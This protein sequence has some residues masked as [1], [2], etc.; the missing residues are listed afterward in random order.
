MRQSGFLGSVLPIAAIVV[1]YSR[2]TECTQ[3]SG[4]MKGEDARFQWPQEEA[5]PRDYVDVETNCSA[6]DG[7][8]HRIPKK[9]LEELLAEAPRATVK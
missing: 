2:P 9:L 3:E 5:R 7:K 4:K 6:T 1:V 8:V